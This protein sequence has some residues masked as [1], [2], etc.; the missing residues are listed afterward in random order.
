MIV[1]I[2]IA[3]FMV[4]GMGSC[5]VCVAFAGSAA[6]HAADFMPMPTAVNA[7]TKGGGNAT[8]GGGV[9]GEPIGIQECDDFF[10]KAAAC[11]KTQDPTTRA[12][13][14]RLIDGYREVWTAQAKSP[15]LR[16][17]LQIACKK[18][19]ND[20]RSNGCK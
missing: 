10:A 15:V 12:Y 14:Q 6:R 1:L 8:A 16:V 7:T 3:G 4:L 11:Y 2:V 19:L 5:L 18:A 20:F 17:E 13:A 9:I